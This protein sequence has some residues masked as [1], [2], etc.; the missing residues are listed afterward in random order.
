MSM[1]RWLRPTGLALL[2]A[3][4]GTAETN[5]HLV[6]HR[7]LPD[8]AAGSPADNVEVGTMRP[9]L[10]SVPLSALTATPERRSSRPSV[11]RRRAR[12]LH[13]R[14]KRFQ[15]RRGGWSLTS[16]QPREVTFKHG[17]RSEVLAP[18]QP[19]AAAP[20]GR[21]ADSGGRPTMSGPVD[22]GFSPSVPRSTPENGESDGL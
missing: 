13:R 18:Q 16:V 22:P 20:A 14:S 8:D 9:P 21:P 1:A 19:D 10:W 2:G 7:M 4:L 3:V 6:A 11:G 5:R 15:H 12:S 17:E